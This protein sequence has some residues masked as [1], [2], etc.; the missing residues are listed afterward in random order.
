[1]KPIALLPLALDRHF[2]ERAVHAGLGGL[3]LSE[4]LA[5]WR[6]ERLRETVRRA[7]RH[8]RFYRGRLDEAFAPLACRADTPQAAE[9]L[10]AACLKHLPH[11]F[12][13]DL[14]AGSDAFLA[15]GHS[16]TAGVIS[17]PTSGTTGPSKRIYC[18]EDDLAHT[19]DFFTWGMQLLPAEALAGTVALLMS[20][21]RP[22]SVGDLLTRALAGIGASCAALG[23]M[24]DVETTLKALLERKPT[25]LVGVPGQLFR[26][27]RHLES[28]RLRG[29]VRAVLCSG[30]TLS[31]PVRS[32]ISEALDCPTFA[33]YGLTETGLGGAVECPE[34]AGCHMREADMIFEI[35]DSEG[36]PAPK[37]DWGELCLTTL[38]RAAMPLLR[39]HTGDEARILP[40]PCACG[41]IFGLLQVR[42]RLC[43]TVSLPNGERLGIE[44]L[45]SALFA[46][47]FVEDATFTLCGGDP[48]RLILAVRPAPESPA[49]APALL[50]EH[51]RHAFEI[52]PGVRI[53]PAG[54]PIP[55]CGLCLVPAWASPEAFPSRPAPKR[56][57][58]RSTDSR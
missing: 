45:E 32:A 4:A 44:D 34:L 58:Q 18:T 49:D 13:H 5:L 51:L 53:V 24:E 19:R 31:S 41:S 40:N 15:V 27:A 17:L 12:G 56:R 6:L 38:T 29:H 22:G 47:P 42:G 20:G 26:L 8:S 14:A 1:M 21:N 55:D 3:P 39:H 16:E 48:P 43:D 50:E 52:L 36:D 2:A 35:L 23:F 54:A 37:G 46:L 57:I 25:C 33:H 10:T 28:R 9:A 30:D 7:A 11:T